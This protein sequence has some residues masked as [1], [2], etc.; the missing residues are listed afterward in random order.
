VVLLQFVTILPYNKI[1]TTLKDHTLILTYEP[2]MTHYDAA[3]RLYAL[4]RQLLGV[5]LGHRAHS[6]IIPMRSGYGKAREDIP[7]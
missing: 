1:C 3:E 4:Y 7:T 2:L 6:I 5:S